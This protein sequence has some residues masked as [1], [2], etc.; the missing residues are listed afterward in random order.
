MN[1]RSSGMEQFQAKKYRLSFAMASPKEADDIAI[2]AGNGKQEK[3]IKEVHGGAIHA[4]HET[5]RVLSQDKLDDETLKYEA[6][7]MNGPLNRGKRIMDAEEKKVLARLK[8]YEKKAN[9]FNKGAS[10]VRGLYGA[11][12]N[13]LDFV[14]SQSMAGVPK[15]I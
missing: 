9:A 11:G 5:E 4:E 12:N 10:L 6:E 13:R 15:E 8:G 1:N 7:R 2:H 3:Q 14:K